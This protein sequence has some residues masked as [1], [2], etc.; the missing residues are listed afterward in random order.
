[1]QGTTGPLKPTGSIG[2]PERAFRGCEPVGFKGVRMASFLKR[3]ATETLKG[4]RARQRRGELG[5][6]RRT[7]SKSY[8]KRC[9][10]HSLPPP[11]LCNPSIAS[12][13]LKMASASDLA[14]VE[15]PERDF[16]QCE[17]VGFKARRFQWA[18]RTY[19]VCS[20]QATPDSD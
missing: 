9:A 12:P 19:L 20:A 3:G 18:G 4:P 1:M 14:Q 17:P 8:A 13:E 11:S 15:N 16:T 7:Q 10:P 6:S 5:D 2:F